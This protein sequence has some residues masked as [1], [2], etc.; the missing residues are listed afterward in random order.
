MDT[1]FKSRILNN[2]KSVNYNPAISSNSIIESKKSSVVKYKQPYLQVNNYLSEFETKEAKKLARENLGIVQT[3]LSTDVIFSDNVTITT[4]VGVHKVDS[5]GNKILEIKGMNLQ[6]VFQ[7]LYSESSQPS[8]E[9][10]RIS[11]ISQSMGQKEV[12]TNIS[13]SYSIQFFSGK[14]QYGPNT[15]VTITQLNVSDSNGGS[16]SGSTGTFNQFQITDS[17]NYGIT[18]NATYSDGTIPVNNL[19]QEYPEGQIKSS[20][21]QTQLGY[22]TGYRKSFYGTITSKNQSITSELIR[23]LQGYSSNA[24]QNNSQFAI[25]IPLNAIRIIIAYPAH[26]RQL[27][28]V[29]DVNGF[30]TPIESEFIKNKTIVQVKGANDYAAIDYQVYY[31]DY[32]NPNNKVNTYK[33]TI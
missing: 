26:L 33:V 14:Y 13:P 8:I 11:I 20:T 15:N 2:N 5:T 21:L 10:P 6:Q 7:Y 4:D 29:L 27:T 16:Q 25:N 12:G 22:I 30:N 32:A 28:K 17:T 1:V 18:A 31:M 24:L 23:S 3:N 9:L 19:G